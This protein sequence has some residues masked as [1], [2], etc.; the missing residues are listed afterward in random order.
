MNT[1]RRSGRARVYWLTL[2]TPR[3]DERQEVARVVNAAIEV[4]AQPYRAHVRVL[5]MEELFTPGGRYRDAMTVDGR[6]QIVR[7]PDGIHL[8]GRGAELAADA[9][10]EAVRRDFPDQGG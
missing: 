4:A 7:E 5:D 6:R 10:L 1:Y 3:D 8:N 9:V 2:P